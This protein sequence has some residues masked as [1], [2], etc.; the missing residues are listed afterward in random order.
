MTDIAAIRTIVL[1]LTRIQQIM[2]AEQPRGI[3]RNKSISEE[4]SGIPESL[5][6]QEVIR[7]TMLNA[8]L[9]QESAEGDKLRQQLAEK[10]KNDPTSD[11][12]EHLKWD[13]V[14]LYITEQEKA[15]TMKIDEPKTPY[16]GGFNPKGEYYQDDGDD[17]ADIPDFELGESEHHDEKI[18]SLNG[19]EIVKD[20]NYEDEEPEEEEEEPLTA[21]QRH[22]LFEAKRKAH[23]HLKG[24]VLHHSK[25]N[26]IN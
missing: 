5:D 10:H 12:G 17:S 24:D 3:L 22:A 21:E 16:E 19:G 2:T 23:Y 20:E 26:A 14:N 15:A 25:D 4:S 9:A 13:E 1:V 11:N 7:N 8:Q 18:Q 6:R